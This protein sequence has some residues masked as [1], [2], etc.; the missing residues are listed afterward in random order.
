V[1]RCDAVCREYAA[2]KVVTEQ[3][4]VNRARKEQKREAKRQRQRQR[5]YTV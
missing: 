4:V 2:L 5:E 3:D 1:L